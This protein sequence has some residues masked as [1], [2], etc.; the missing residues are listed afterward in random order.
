MDSKLKIPIKE[1]QAFAK[2]SVSN[3]LFV[4]LSGSHAYGFP[5]A[6]SDYD[7]RGAYIAKTKE[8]L[9]LQKPLETIEKRD[10]KMELVVH[11]IERMLHLLLSPSG[12]VF[13]QIHSPYP[14]LESKPFKQLKQLSKSVVCKALHNHYSGFAL[15]IY[16]KARTAGW[17]DIKEDLYLMRVLMT[18][19][20]LLETGN[21]IVNLPELNKKF[22][23]DVVPQLIELREQSETARGLVNLDKEATELFNRLDAAYKASNLPDQVQNVDKFNDFLLKIRAADMK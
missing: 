8:L 4:V 10:T 16:K 20:T 2:E 12:Y 22:K 9:S 23:L 1:L 19:I 3:P 11:E 5:S 21:V 17:A 6:E 15:S 18:G 13:E 14:V 7:L